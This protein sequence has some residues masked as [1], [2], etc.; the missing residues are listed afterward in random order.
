MRVAAHALL[1]TALVALAADPAFALSGSSGGGGILVA[2]LIVVLGPVPWALVAGGLLGARGL[3]RRP[4]IGA[5]AGVALVGVALASAMLL[6]IAVHDRPEMPLVQKLVRGLVPSLLPSLTVAAMLAALPLGAA[7]AAV[8][9]AW[10][11]T[12]D[13]LLIASTVGVIG[14]L[15]C[16]ASRAFV[17]LLLVSAAGAATCIATLLAGIVAAGRSARA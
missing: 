7:L 6:M 16:I 8:A 2:V 1:S 17:L 5:I 15:G 13:R 10:P 12:G 3:A 11:D 9:R 4:T 14:S